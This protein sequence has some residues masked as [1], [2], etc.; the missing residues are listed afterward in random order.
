MS[1]L[2]LLFLFSLSPMRATSITFCLIKV[3]GYPKTY[4]P[5]RYWN[6]IHLISKKDKR[7][8]VCVGNFNDIVCPA[9]NL[10][11]L[12]RC[13]QKLAAFWQI[14]Q[15]DQFF[16]LGFNGNL[17][18]WKR[19]NSTNWIIEEQLYSVVINNEWRILFPKLVLWHLLYV[20]FDQRPIF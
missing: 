14:L 3:Y 9:E 4:S 1:F 17:F 2:F 13:V 19:G 18:T 5:G 16:D 11:G 20:V 8:W 7:S 15:E 6:L 12:T 10:G